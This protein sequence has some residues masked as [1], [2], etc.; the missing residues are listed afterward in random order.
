MRAG[1]FARMALR[2]ELALL[3]QALAAIAILALIAAFVFCEAIPALESVGLTN[4]LLGSEW[5]P[6]YGKYGALP[7]VCGSLL[8]V[9]GCLLISVP[10]GIA[11][12]VFL[13]ELSPRWFSELVKPV[14]EL[15]ASVP[16]VVY[17]AFGLVVLAPVLSAFIGVGVGKMALTASLLL[18]AMVLP[19]IVSISSEAIAS[20]PVE[21]RRASIALGATK[22][23]TIRNVVLPAA[24]PGILASIMLGFGRA[25]GETVAVLMV[26]GCV[27]S[28]PQPI[29]N[30]LSPVHTLTAAIALEMGETPVGSMHYHVLFALGAVLFSITFLVNMLS[31]IALRNVNRGPVEA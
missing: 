6:Q 1:R 13:T 2:A 23:Q 3:P 20:V 26:C 27:P 22:W 15:M 7:L 21:Y 9:A 18:S 28:I 31:D 25:I 11:V 17:G 4:L 10:L 30:L 24:R 29:F 16:S 8:V 12:A 19:T 14:V 5:A